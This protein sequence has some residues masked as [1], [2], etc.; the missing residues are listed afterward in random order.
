MMF[1]SAKVKKIQ[2]V[3][4][5]CIFFLIVYSS[6]FK[7]LC[8]TASLYKSKKTKLLYVDEMFLSGCRI[9]SRNDKVNLPV[10]VFFRR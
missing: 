4:L 7:R 6:E 3:E 10:N 1:E 2:I 5:I 9:L 8:I